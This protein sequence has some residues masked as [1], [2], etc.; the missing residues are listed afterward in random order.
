MTDK[1]GKVTYIRSVPCWGTGE[2]LETDV[3]PTTNTVTVDGEEKQ[4]G[5]RI[6]IGVGIVVILVLMGVWMRSFNCFAF[7]FTI[8]LSGEQA[9]GSDGRK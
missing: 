5:N 9:H 4:I 2:D 6:L 8:L 1:F 3:A 7:S